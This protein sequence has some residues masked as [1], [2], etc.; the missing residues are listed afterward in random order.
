MSTPKTKGFDGGLPVWTPFPGFSWLFSNPGASLR[1]LSGQDG[2]TILHA[3]LS[4]PA[5]ALYRELETF[6]DEIADLLGPGFVPLPGSSFHV[7]LADGINVDNVG[8]LPSRWSGAFGRL[9]DALPGSCLELGG[10]VADGVERRLPGALDLELETLLVRKDAVLAA[11]LR[12]SARAAA[13]YEEVSRQRARLDGELVESFGKPA[14]AAWRPHVSLG[15]F[16]PGGAATAREQIDSINAA[17]RER[18]WHPIEFG[19]T[20]LYAFTDMVSFLRPVSAPTPP[21]GPRSA[22][23]ARSGDGERD[24][25]LARACRKAGVFDIPGSQRWM[26]RPNELDRAEDVVRT[27]AR[28]TLRP[29]Q[30][31]VAW[32]GVPTLVFDRFSDELLHLK[33]RLEAELPRLGPENPGSLQPKISLAAMNDGRSMGRWAA[34]RLYRACRKL[35]GDLANAP[36]IAVNEL[37]VVAFRCRSLEKAWLRHP[38]A[39][40]SASG[41]WQVELTPAGRAALEVLVAEHRVHVRRNVLDSFSPRAVRAGV[42]SGR[43]RLSRYKEPRSEFTLVVDMASTSLD[44]IIDD[45]RSAVDGALPGRFTWFDRRSRH[46]TIRGL[47]PRPGAAGAVPTNPNAAED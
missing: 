12:P 13:L 44:P 39:L 11:M 5:H 9:F 31:V 35:D 37:S 26:L 14:A 47:M 1:P 25:D 42:S 6:R 2:L 19:R 7:T 10:L 24:G 27:T 4:D 40:A 23:G 21:N 3:D 41:E 29:R 28:S 32:N 20:A 46:I 30:F 43:S 45:F 36:L 33:V 34:W 38:I 22:S 17:A 8:R 15:Y 18:D 16:L